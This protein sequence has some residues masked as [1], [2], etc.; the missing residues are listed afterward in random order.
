MLFYHFALSLSF[1][2]YICLL[3]M[4]GAPSAA[5]VWYMQ[6]DCRLLVSEKLH[7]WNCN[8]AKRLVKIVSYS[9]QLCDI[10][11]YFH[12]E[13]RMQSGVLEAWLAFWLGGKA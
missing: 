10:K 9:P 5:L 3:L 6:L 1:I 2:P 12:P 8:V 4:G 11:T 7:I 13:L